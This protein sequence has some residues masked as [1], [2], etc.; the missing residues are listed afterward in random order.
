MIVFRILLL[1]LI[2]F[3]LFAQGELRTQNIGDLQLTGGGEIKDCIVAYRIFGSANIDSS[4]IIIY[5]T[6]FA[7][8][9]E[10]LRG[11]MGK[12]K[13]VDT[14]NYCVIAIDAL[15]DG[16]SSSPSNTSLPFPEISIKDMVNSQYI[17]LTK[18]LNIKKIHAA[19]GGSMGGMQVFQWL[20][21]YPDF[22]KKA[23]PY[24]GTPRPAV[25]DM[26]IWHNQLEMIE[27]AEKCGLPEQEVMRAPNLIMNLLAYTHEYRAER[28]SRD[29]FF[30]YYNSHRRPQPLTFTV[31]NYKAQLKAMIRHD[32]YDGGNPDDVV[33]KIK[34]KVFVIAGRYDN[35]V[36]H[37]PAAEFAKLTGSKIY[38]SESN[39]GHICVGCE[40]GKISVIIDEFLND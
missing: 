19:I 22:M 13:I 16:F 18:Y 20:V 27:T 33:K 38:L 12:G 28:T 32:I 3:N 10:Q 5:P 39:C 2:N 34:A 29:S 37:K 6:W 23:V 40:L 26:A 9:S 11:L 17:L 35:L 15:G 8:N 30:V 36:Y 24:V 7:G 4:N 31:E 1:A 14:S 21:S 25:T